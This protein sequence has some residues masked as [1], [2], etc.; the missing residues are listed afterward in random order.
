MTKEN[1]NTDLWYTETAASSFL[2]KST[3]YLL[4]RRQRGLS[5][6][7]ACIHQRGVKEIYLYKEEALIVWCKQHGIKNPVECFLTKKH[8]MGK[9]Q[10]RI[11]HD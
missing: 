3:Q 11:E 9:N 1:E 10:T 5:I 6:P 8:S 4:R 2:G 7:R